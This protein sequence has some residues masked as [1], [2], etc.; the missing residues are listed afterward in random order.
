[1]ESLEHLQA[2]LARVNER[3]SSAA[4]ASGRAA[5]DVALIAVTKTHPAALVRDAFAA[6]LTHFG[7]NRVQEAADKFEGL[8][9]LRAK[10]ATFHLIGHLQS[11]KVRRAVEVFDTVQSLDSVELARRLHRLAIEAG[12]V[13]P[14]TIQVDLA[15][16]ASKTGVPE[17]KLFPLLESIRALGGLRRDGLMILPPYLEDPEAVRPYFA[18]LRALRDAARERDLLDGNVLSMGMSHDF[19]VAI[20]EGATHIRVGTALFGERPRPRSPTPETG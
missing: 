8:A 1:M 15:G 11:N 16:E 17:A 3:I 10:G 12:R 4:K 5:S 6:G 9:D 13:L 14:V 20:E 18:R 19:D 7:E 2:A